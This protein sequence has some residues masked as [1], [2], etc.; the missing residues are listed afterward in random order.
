VLAAERADD[1]D[2][3][4]VDEAIDDEA[5]FAFPVRPPDEARFIDHPLRV[6]KV[7]VVLA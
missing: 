3:E 6:A 4:R 7:D 2:F 1:D 5:D